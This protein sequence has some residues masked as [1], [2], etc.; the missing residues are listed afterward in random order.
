MENVRQMDWMA[1]ESL[2]KERETGKKKGKGKVKKEGVKVDQAG[3]HISWF[4][5][6]LFGA[7]CVPPI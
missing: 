7:E 3:A 4:L 2:R 6:L 5:V 1:P